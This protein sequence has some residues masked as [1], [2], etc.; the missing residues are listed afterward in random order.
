MELPPSLAGTNSM[1][2]VNGLGSGL[3]MV[4]DTVLG[5]GTLG[6]ATVTALLRVPLPTLFIASLLKYQV[7]ALATA[8]V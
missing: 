2:T 8:I 5:A 6:V 3:S 1:V 4:S 7:P